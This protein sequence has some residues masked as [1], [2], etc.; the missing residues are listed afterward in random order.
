MGCFWSTG[1]VPEI[2]A[3]WKEECIC[4]MGG[5]EDQKSSSFMIF[6]ARVDEFG[7]EKA[8]VS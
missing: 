5:V 4:R 3:R 8:N 2:R 6:E 7:F 1:A